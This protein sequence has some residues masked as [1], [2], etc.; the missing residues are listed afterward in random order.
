MEALIGQE[1]DQKASHP[2]TLS[3]IRRWALA[4]YWPA[5]PPPMFL[6]GSHDSTRRDG[7]FAP[8]DFNPFAWTV[9]EGV[10]GFGDAHDTDSRFEGK[11]GAKGPGLKR[12][13]NGGLDVNYTGVKMRSGDVIRS[14]SRIVEY[15]ERQGRLGQML[16]TTI[17]TTWTNQLDEVVKTQ[18]MTVIRY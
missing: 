12:S 15:R 17:E 11:L 13:V 14:V 3:D 10:A 7:P 5:E 16:F 8:E 1:Y 4:V 2:I 9:A 18:K 6:D